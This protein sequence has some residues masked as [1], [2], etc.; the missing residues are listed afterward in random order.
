LPCNVPARAASLRRVRAA[1]S[2]DAESF[3]PAG[4]PPRRASVRA[5]KEVAHGLPEVTKRLLLDCGA[6][7]GEPRVIGAGCRELSALLHAGRHWPTTRTPPRVLLDRQIP[8]VPGVGAVLPQDG[9]LFD[10]RHK[11]VSEY[12][13]IISI[14]GRRERRSLPG[15][16]AGASS[17]LHFR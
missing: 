11:S 16:L 17:A 13:N 9:F 5:T 4:F 15:L 12:A 1:L 8:D 14:N 10:S 7:R 6:P 3:V 2:G